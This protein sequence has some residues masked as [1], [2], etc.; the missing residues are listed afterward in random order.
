MREKRAEIV[1]GRQVAA[2]EEWRRVSSLSLLVEVEV[3]NER[4]EDREERKGEWG[5]E[6][7]V[8]DLE[9]DGKSKVLLGGGGEGRRRRWEAD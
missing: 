6:K 2:A 8:A 1:I 3:I 9:G 7:G 4:R 5:E